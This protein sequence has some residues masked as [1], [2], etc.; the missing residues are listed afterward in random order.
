MNVWKVGSRWSYEGSRDTSV[1][2][3]FV[4]NSVVFVGYKGDEF[5]EKVRK[6]DYFAIADGI[7]V[8]AVA[9]ATSEPADLEE[10]VPEKRFEILDF[11][12]R[13]FDY[14]ENKNYAKGC[15]VDIKELD[16]K[17][18]FDYSQG[19]F[20]FVNK[21][22]KKIV[23]LYDSGSKLYSLQA[24]I[25][26]NAEL[27]RLFEDWKE[28]IKG[29]KLY[30]G[31]SA[32]NFIK[33]GFY[34][35]YTRQSKKILFIGRE[36]YGIDGEKSYIDLLLKCYK[37][38]SVGDKKL[39]AWQFHNL[40]FKITYSLCNNCFDWK[41]I[42]SASKLTKNFGTPDGI[43]FAFMNISK[44][45]NEET[46]SLNKKLVNSFINNAEDFIAK[47]IKL[48]NP[49]LVITMNFG[50]NV[51]LCGNLERIEEK[52]TPDVGLYW[53]DLGTRKILLAD[54][55]HFSAPN[56][57]PER[58]IWKPLLKALELI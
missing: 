7:T 47:E 31:Y 20:F 35:F 24:E 4:K 5:L 21:Y 45:S 17:Q 11:E 46:W 12:K 44:F 36:A 33:D 39:D 3:L 57:S 15:K 26:L 48:L 16:K 28:H 27:H 8:K 50:N 18:Y 43:S 25:K 6:G 23:N 41:K 58:E 40:M 13:F 32:K 9:K 1:F 10:L 54:T 49:D 34:P 14:R 29:V 56:K 53:L 2:S 37:E 55:W 51:E 22:E 30:D 38:N 19:S 42:P 52:S